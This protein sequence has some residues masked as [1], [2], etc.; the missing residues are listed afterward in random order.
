MTI[1]THPEINIVSL[2]IEHLEHED[3]RKG[4]LE[5]E[6]FLPPP[7]DQQRPGFRDQFQ[8]AAEHELVRA[9]G[10]VMQ[11]P[12]YRMFARLP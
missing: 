6:V 5:D 9:P 2:L 10:F 8:A 12:C 7:A 3:D 4:L 11:R 1:I